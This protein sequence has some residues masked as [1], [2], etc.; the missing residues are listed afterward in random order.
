MKLTLN[1]TESSI[2]NQGIEL[3]RVSS[4]RKTVPGKGVG[5]GVIVAVEVGS[6]VKVDMTVEVDSTEKVIVGARVN[7][8]GMT[9]RREVSDVGLA[10]GYR[11]PE[12]QPEERV[13]LMMSDLAIS[14][15]I[16]LMCMGR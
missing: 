16:L 2:G 15:G 9:V 1:L 6:G 12:Q 14:S 8:G 13:G 7:V 10:V 4:G 3:P 5:E 11:H